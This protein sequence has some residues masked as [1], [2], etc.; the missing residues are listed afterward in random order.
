M[1]TH[2]R[3]HSLAAVAC[4]R[5]GSRRRSHAGQ[6]LRRNIYRP[7][8]ESRLAE[9]RGTPFAWVLVLFFNSFLSL[10]GGAIAEI[11]HDPGSSSRGYLEDLP[12]LFRVLR[13]GRNVIL[14]VTGLCLALA[15]VY[16]FLS[17][18]RDQQELAGRVPGI[19]SWRAESATA[20]GKPS[21]G[22]FQV[23]GGQILD[24]SGNQWVAKGINVA[25]YGGIA[26]PNQVLTLFPGINFVRLAASNYPS[27]VNLQNFVSTLTSHG[28]VV[29]IEDHNYPITN[30]YTG[31]ALTNED[32]W[33]A[34][35]ATTFAGNPY[36]WYGSQNEPQSATGFEAEQL[37]VY[38]TLRSNGV[39]SPILFQARFIS[40]L[41]P[42][43]YATLTN[44]IWDQHFYGGDFPGVN[45]QTQLQN[46]LLSKITRD[47]TIHSADGIMPVIIGEFGPSAGDV[48]PDP[49][50]QQ[51]IMS[52]EWAANNGYIKGMVGW[53]YGNGGGPD[54]MTVD[55][56]HLTA[57]GQQMKSIIA[58]T[59]TPPV[60]PPRD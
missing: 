44:V 59:A 23:V 5:Q 19:R 45:D 43:D 15:G 24:P 46:A 32:N 1:F 52:V 33:F 8:R 7:C 41:N 4:R 57:W 34:S 9:N 6:C 26:D 13:R 39:T 27:P 31:S 51:A 11:L 18:S 53:F 29:E 47:Q 42:S 36:V 22:G 28:V 50:G 48:S 10:W 54:T 55:N 37:S 14:L 30:P 58:G 2:P 38:N 49:N 60:S 56:V 25:Y 16:L 3:E 40:S 21:T 20:L 17:P 35:M 12:R